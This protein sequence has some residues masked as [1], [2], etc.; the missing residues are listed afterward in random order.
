MRVGVTRGA[1]PSPPTIRLYGREA[2][3]EMIGAIAPRDMTGTYALLMGTLVLVM[4][5]VV[6]TVLVARRFR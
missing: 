6:V 1:E 3:V 4:A 5:V 2:R